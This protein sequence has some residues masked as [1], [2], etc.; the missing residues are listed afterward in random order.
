ML[1][2]KK[3][4]HRDAENTEKRSLF[5]KV[6]ISALSQHTAQCISLIAPY[7]VVDHSNP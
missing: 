7:D 2:S 3:I 4:H 1:Y 5:L 6:I